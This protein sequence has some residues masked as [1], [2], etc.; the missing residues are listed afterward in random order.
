[1]KIF[2]FKKLLALTPALFFARCDEGKLADYYVYAEVTKE[3]PTAKVVPQKIFSSEFGIADGF[4]VSN[5]EKVGGIKAEVHF[6]GLP[7][8]FPAGLQ[9]ELYADD[10]KIEMPDT[11][12]YTITTVINSVRYF[13]YKATSLNINDVV[14]SVKRENNIPD[15][16]TYF[17]V[18]GIFNNIIINQPRDPRKITLALKTLINGRVVLERSH[19]YE[20]TR[21]K[22]YNVRSRPFG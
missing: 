4:R 13:K 14:T 5:P 22:L 1:L 3:K 19:T 7:A 15:S 6:S 10:K 9:F 21:P 2:S 16:I 12:D 8:D 18:A 17:S 11:I 20:L